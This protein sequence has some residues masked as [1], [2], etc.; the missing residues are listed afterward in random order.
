MVLA[1]IVFS[2]F[3]IAIIIVGYQ[4]SLDKTSLRIK[5]TSQLCQMKH[6]AIIKFQQAKAI[7]LYGA[8]GHNAQIIASINQEISNKTSSHLKPK[9]VLFPETIK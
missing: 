8:M 7:G 5:S 6:Q 1:S 4:R 3:I 9:N 2:L